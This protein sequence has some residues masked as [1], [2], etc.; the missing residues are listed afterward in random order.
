MYLQLSVN[1]CDGVIGDRQIARQH[2]EGVHLGSKLHRLNRLKKSAA[3][4]AGV[5]RETCLAESAPLGGGSVV[6]DRVA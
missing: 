4:F 6:M 1:G 3:W 2:S 5:V